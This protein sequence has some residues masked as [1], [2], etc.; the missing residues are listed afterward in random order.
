[1]T[2][3]LRWK[4]KSDLYRV[5]CYL[6][7]EYQEA[8]DLKFDLKS[9]MCYV[10]RSPPTLPYKSNSAALLPNTPPCTDKLS[11]IKEME[12]VYN[13]TSPSP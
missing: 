3:K 2:K 5:S 4:R 1:M 7:F 9:E 10:D 6:Y 11:I 12:P 8:S 13:H